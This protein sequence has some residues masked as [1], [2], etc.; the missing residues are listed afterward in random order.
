MRATHPLLLALALGALAMGQGGQAK[1]GRPE[2]ARIIELQARARQEAVAYSQVRAAVETGARPT[3]DLAMARR[4]LKAAQVAMYDQIGETQR[5]N[6]AIFHDLR[7][8]NAR[9]LRQERIQARAEEQD[10]AALSVAERPS[11]EARLSLSRQL[12]ESYQEN[13][14]RLAN[15]SAAPSRPK[16]PILPPC[17]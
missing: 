12:V 9:R 11:G 7:R 17:F 4:S 8:Q 10:L 5:A 6:A 3:S 14:G 13:A 2:L 16:L 1:A 15:L